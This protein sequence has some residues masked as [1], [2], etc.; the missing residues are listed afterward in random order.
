MALLKTKYFYDTLFDMPNFD[1]FFPRITVP[2]TYVATRPEDSSEPSVNVTALLLILDSAREIHVGV[3]PHF[4]PVTLGK[5]Q[6][7]M[8]QELFTYLGVENGANITVELPVPLPPLEG[9]MWAKILAIMSA[10]LDVKPDFDWSG[11]TLTFGEDRINFDDM[12]PT[13][14]WGKSSTIK[15]N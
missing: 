9:D 14:D 1:G 13:P 3:A 2:R 12:F 5:G 10:E 11:R 6:A 4:P 8:N 7:M 15:M